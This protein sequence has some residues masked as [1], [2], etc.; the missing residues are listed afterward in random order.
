MISAVIFDLDGLIIDSETPEVLAWEAIYARYGWRFPVAEW[1]QNIGRNDGPWDPLTPF[2]RPESPASPEIVAGLW[3]RQADALMDGYFTPLP[4]VV[5]L[6]SRLR[7]RSLPTAVA[8]SSRRAWIVRVL[9]RLGLEDQFDAVAGGD[10]VQ[11]AKPEPDVYLLAA[12]RLGVVP[13]A[14]V[15]LEDSPNGVRSAKAAGMACIAVPSALTRQ[16]DFSPAD[17]VVEGLEQVTLSA[18]DALGNAEA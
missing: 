15:A 2:H 6:L 17:L 4:G 3:R 18:I 12:R 7:Q 1:L 10:E 14:C 13:H 9:A 8:S 11:R 5:P 16:L